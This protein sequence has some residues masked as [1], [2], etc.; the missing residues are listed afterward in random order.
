MEVSNMHW[1]TMFGVGTVAVAL[2]AGGCASG[3][4]STGGSAGTGNTSATVSARDIA[5]VG[6]ALIARDGKAL[7]FSDQESS[8]TIHCVGGCLQFWTPL[9]VGSGGAPTTGSGVTGKLS[10]MNRPDG[11]AQVTY[12]GKP[13]YVFS[14]DAPGQAKGNGFSDAFGGTT[15]TWHA[16]VVSGAASAGPSSSNPYGSG[17]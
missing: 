12:D 14:L 16:A 6:T 9:T 11:T 1:K 2:A 7:Y 4:N 17:Y 5:G 3:S 10:T 8:G 13:L 15:F